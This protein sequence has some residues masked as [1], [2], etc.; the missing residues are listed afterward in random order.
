MSN[1]QSAFSF[2]LN[3]SLYFEKG[4]EVEE[5][6]G[7]SLDPEISI[8][9]FNDYISIRGA[10][11][12]N[13]EYVKADH[14][15]AVEE[16]AEQQ[17]EFQAKRYVERVVDAED[18]ISSFT[19]RFPVEISVPT[20]RVEDLNEITVAVQSFDYEIPEQRQLKLYSTIEIV[21]VNGLSDAKPEEE[22]EEEEIPQTRESIDESFEFEIKQP[23]DQQQE[24]ETAEDS[25]QADEYPELQAETNSHPKEDS[26]PVEDPDEKDRWKYKETKS[27]KEFFDK[28]KSAEQDEI[29]DKGENAVEAAETAES[30]V[31]GKQEEEETTVVEEHVQKAAEEEVEDVS[32][33]A[34]MF[35]KSEEEEYSRMR[36]CIVQDKDTIESIAERYE[37]SALQLIKQNGLDDDYDI[38]EGQLLH[39]PAKRR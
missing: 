34:D 24:Q 4:Q 18:G 31:A 12:L 32:Y 27:L 22:S 38:S 7:I 35:R 39:I 23:E 25:E 13:G 15:N 6:R 2:E 1:D 21:G 9:S 30:A 5:L 16:G 28:G 8:Q 33:L 20:Y 26:H 17:S 36:L 11:E 19:H 14:T 37:I 29:E 10:I 3:E